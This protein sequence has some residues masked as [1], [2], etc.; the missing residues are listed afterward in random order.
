M[1]T[2]YQ[3]KLTY[4]FVSFDAADVYDVTDGRRRLHAAAFPQ[5]CCH[6]KA[7]I[8]TYVLQQAASKKLL[9]RHSQRHYWLQCTQVPPRRRPYIIKEEGATATARCADTIEIFILFFNT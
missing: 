5:C 8:F 9:S 4:P 6:A 2:I 3:R 1:G 7:F